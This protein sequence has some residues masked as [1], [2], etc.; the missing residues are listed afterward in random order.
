MHHISSFDAELYDQL[1]QDIPEEKLPRNAYYGDGS[2]IEIS[3][4]DELKD[5]YQKSAVYFPWQKGD[6]LLL[7]NMLASHGRAPFSGP[8]EVV[9]GMSE[10][11]M[12]TDL[13]FA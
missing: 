2:P 5:V 3:V 9:V 7:D 10:P 13:E 4:L 12:N 8:R 6:I 11:I 1:L